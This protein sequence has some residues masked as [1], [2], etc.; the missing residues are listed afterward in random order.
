MSANEP[1]KDEAVREPEEDKAHQPVGQ[2]SD[3]GNKVPLFLRGSSDGDKGNE[4]DEKD[5]VGE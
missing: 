1:P 2:L 5:E 3:G 4:Q